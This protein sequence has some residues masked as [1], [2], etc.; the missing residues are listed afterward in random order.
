MWLARQN[1][2]VRSTIQK[3][4]SPMFLSLRPIPLHHQKA[5]ARGPALAEEVV[6]ELVVL[7]DVTDALRTT[8]AFTSPLIAVLRPYNL[9]GVG[10]LLQRQNFCL[11]LRRQRLLPRFPPPQKGTLH[12][13]L[14]KIVGLQ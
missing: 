2:I 3:P 1:E 14:V 13:L 9:N 7:K 5:A 11:P 4:I 6:T 12:S 10:L 8:I